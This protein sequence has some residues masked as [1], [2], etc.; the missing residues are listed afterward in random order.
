MSDNQTLAAIVGV[1]PTR[2]E[3]ITECEA[4]VDEEVR[5]KSGFSGA[6]IKLGFKTVKAIK[7]GFIRA[8]I[9]GL[10]DAWLVKLEPFHEGWRGAG[11]SFAEYV[12]SRSDEVAEAML[13]VTDEQAEVT[14][15]KTARKMYKKMRPS[16]KENVVAAVP[17]LGALIEK[18]LGS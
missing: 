7:P 3:V 2:G 6:A 9:D 16:A 15:H 5:A 10:L 18:R 14:K 8:A 12:T 1:E 13:S 17:K 11:G 4:L